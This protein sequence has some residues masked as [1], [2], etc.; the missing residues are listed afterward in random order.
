MTDKLDEGAEK[1]WLGWVTPDPR[2]GEQADA[3]PAAARERAL[4]EL[5]RLPWRTIEA[6]E[7]VDVVLRAAHPEAESEEAERLKMQ[8]D[9]ARRNFRRLDEKAAGLEARTEALADAV[10]VAVQ[11]L[12]LTRVDSKP[13]DHEDGPSRAGARLRLALRAFRAAH[14]EADRAPEDCEIQPFSSRA[15]ERGTKGCDEVEHD[16][17]PEWRKDPNDV[18]AYMR[19]ERAPESDREKF[20]AY[21]SLSAQCGDGRHRECFTSQVCP[22]EC[23]RSREVE[24]APEPLSGTSFADANQEL[25]RPDR[26]PKRTPEDKR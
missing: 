26:A 8:R 15:C 4:A 19:A 11:E 5:R 12:P 25:L 10:Q 7:I 6:D 24:R 3:I 23:H 2:R 13:S 22:C 18:D 21:P 9:V 17:G 1:R 20:G 16:R 14:P